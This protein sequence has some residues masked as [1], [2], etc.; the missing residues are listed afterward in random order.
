[1]LKFKLW[2]LIPFIMIATVFCFAL[3]IFYGSYKMVLENSKTELLGATGRLNEVFDNFRLS[4]RLKAVNIANQISIVQD[5]MKKK[6]ITN[7]KGQIDKLKMHSVIVGK[8]ELNF[9]PKT[10]YILAYYDIADKALISLVE[11][12]ILNIIIS[13]ELFSKVKENN[14]SCDIFTHKN[15]IYIISLAPVFMDN[16]VAGSVI[17]VK[18]IDDSLAFSIR[19]VTSFDISIFS[20]DNLIGSTFRQTAPEVLVDILQAKDKVLLHGRLKGKESPYFPSDIPAMITVFQ[21]FVPGKDIKMAVTSQL[22]G[23]FSELKDIQFVV[24]VVLIGVLII[25][26]VVSFSISRTIYS[27][28]NLIKDGLLPAIKGNFSVQIPEN[29]IPSPFD[30]LVRMINKLLFVAREKVATPAKASTIFSDAGPKEDIRRTFTGE[31]KVPQISPK[32]VSQEIKPKPSV[33][34]SKPAAI[35]EVKSTNGGTDIPSAVPKPM[36]GE[37][38]VGNELSSEDVGELIEDERAEEYNPEATMVA[39]LEQIEELDRARQVAKATD[40]D[41]FRK[42]FDKYVSMRLDNGESIENLNFDNFLEKIKATKA[43]LMKNGN[44]RDVMI[45]NGKVTLKANPVK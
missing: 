43:E 34:D 39:S 19:D 21:D 11:D 13:S 3:F 28:V 7:L 24:L 14:I 4:N 40:L 42:V 33:Q 9:N 8:L 6:K 17:V 22:A 23:R 36:S 20:Q 25:G 32:P 15:K 12:E 35:T 27:N 44:Y 45:K 37:I 18:V 10:E 31:I 26:I 30:E 16:A 38:F 5:E 29:R 41:E 2:F 1:M